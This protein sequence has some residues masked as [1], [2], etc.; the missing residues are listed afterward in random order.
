MFEV[1]GPGIKAERDAVAIHS[2]RD[3]IENVVRDFQHL[4]EPDIR[5]KYGLHKDSRDWTVPKAKADTIA[6]AKTAVVTRLQ[7]RPFDYQWTWY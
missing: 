7:Y 4:S 6:T 5:T 2:D 1:F 3:A